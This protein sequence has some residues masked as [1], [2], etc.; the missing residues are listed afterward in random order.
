MA[1][2]AASA[3][4][5]ICRRTGDL[6]AVQMLPVTPSLTKKSDAAAGAGRR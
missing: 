5:L 4:G 2:Q 3:A 6:Q 1:G